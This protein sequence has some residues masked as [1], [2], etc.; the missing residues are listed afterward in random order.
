[1]LV[2]RDLSVSPA[3]RERVEELSAELNRFF[4]ELRRV[5]WN[6]RLDAGTVRASCSLVARSGE[7]RA[8]ASHA[9]ARDAVNLVY[10]KLVTQRRRVKMKRVGAR[11]GDRAR[12]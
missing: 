10:D 1:M 8:H 3:V 7:Y 11:R 6:L 4:H 12:D 5:S 9:T 2:V